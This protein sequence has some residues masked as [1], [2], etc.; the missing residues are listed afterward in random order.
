MALWNKSKETGKRS[1]QHARLEGT[2]VEFNF[3]KKK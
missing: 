2:K 3:K 1:I